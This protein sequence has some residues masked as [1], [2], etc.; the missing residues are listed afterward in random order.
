MAPYK[1]L[2]IH[3]KCVQFSSVMSA[4]VL[5]RWGSPARILDWVAISSSRVSCHSRDQTP[6]PASPAPAGEYFTTEP[7]G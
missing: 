2:C 4:R 3:A 5:C 6:L 1:C 7:P